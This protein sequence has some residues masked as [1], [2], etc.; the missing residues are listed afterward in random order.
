MLQNLMERLPRRLEAIIGAKTNSILMLLEMDIQ[1][2]H[3]VVLVR[4]PPSFG[5]IMYKDAQVTIDV[6]LT[7][8]P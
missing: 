3:L 7:V 8:P 2:A 6:G 5:H 4:C 1:Q